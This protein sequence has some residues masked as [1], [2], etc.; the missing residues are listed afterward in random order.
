MGIDGI[1][2]T[3][4]VICTIFFASALQTT[5]LHQTIYALQENRELK[6]ALTMLQESKQQL[7]KNRSVMQMWEIFSQ[8][9]KRRLKRMP[10]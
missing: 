5:K 4:I 7:E 9:L 1:S 2:R 6:N 10:A 8:I 3:A